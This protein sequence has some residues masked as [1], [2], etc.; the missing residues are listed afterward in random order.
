MSPSA[1][2]A[3]IEIT[4]QRQKVTSQSRSPSAGRAW[5]EIHKSWIKL[6]S[7]R[8]SPSAGRA[9]IE[10]WNVV[11]IVLS[12]VCRPPRGGRGLKSKH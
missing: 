4:R 9:W 11:S 10:M 3:W 2:R 5:I 6:V 7:G 1:G 8:E 12:F